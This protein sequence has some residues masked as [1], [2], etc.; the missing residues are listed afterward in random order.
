MSTKIPTSVQKTIQ[1]T[2]QNFKSDFASFKVFVGGLPHNITKSELFSYFCA[3]G[4][5]INID[6]PMNA[7]TGKL[8]GFGFVFFSSPS[9]MEYA[10][11]HESHILKGK[12]IT[13]RRGLE[14]DSAQLMTKD[15]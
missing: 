14:E 9:E 6:L 12:K 5:V 8:K 2:N 11:Q 1:H 7:K 10:L 13:M 15:L 3:F 4:N